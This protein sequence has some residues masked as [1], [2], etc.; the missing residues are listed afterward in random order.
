MSVGNTE[1]VKRSNAILG[2]GD[3]L[4]Y[5]EGLV[6]PNFFVGFMATF[7]LVLL[8]NAFV[9]G[10]V[11]TFLRNYVL[12]KPGEGPSVESQENGFLD[13]TGYGTGSKGTQVKVEL[14]F[15]AD[16]GYKSTGRMLAEAGL[17][18]ALNQDKL[19]HVGGHF[20]PAVGLGDTY[21][22]RLIDTGCQ[23]EINEIKQKSA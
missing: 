8:G 14:Y 4:H 20:T 13:V 5:E 2:Y 3:N 9:M 15:P 1:I 7:G 12:P 23:Y 18:L 22:Q 11:F 10:P 16:P 19:D 6:H 17:T 21:L